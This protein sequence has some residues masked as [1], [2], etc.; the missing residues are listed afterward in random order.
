VR[1]QA[2]ALPRSELQAFC[3]R[4]DMVAG[5]DRDPDAGRVEQAQSSPVDR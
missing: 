2:R 4:G 5:A 1:V 3:S